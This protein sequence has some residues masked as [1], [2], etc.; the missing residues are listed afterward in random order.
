MPRS[1]GLLSTCP[2]I[3]VASE[4]P[5]SIAVSLNDQTKAVLF[6]LVN[7]V[8]VTRDGLAASRNA[9]LANAPHQLALRLGLA[10][11]FAAGRLDLE[12]FSPGT[13]ARNASK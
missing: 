7:P 13:L 1:A 8:G 4:Q 3:T 9:R 12:D 11:F 2:V 10:A 6:Q 5:N